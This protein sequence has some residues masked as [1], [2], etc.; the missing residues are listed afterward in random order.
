MGCLPLLFA[1]VLCFS[2]VTAFKAAVY[3]HVQVVDPSNDRN[4]TVEANLRAYANATLNAAKENADII[5][6][7][8][9]G[10]LF[11]FKDREE[12]SKWAENIPDPGVLPCSSNHTTLLANLSC[13][14]L[15]NKI[16]LVANIIDK[17]PCN[18]SD[19][20]CPRDK[21]RF[22]NT[23]V[24]FDRNGTLVSR[25]HK[26]HLF[27]EPLMSPADPPEF[28]VFDTDF[29][30]V[31]MFICFD[32][33]FAESSQLVDKHNVT[34]AIMS[35]WW[36]DGLPGWYSVAVQ[37]AWSLHNRI[38]L[39]AAGIQN[40]E[41]G[42]LGSGIYAGVRGPLNYTYSP[43][44]KS[45]LLFADLAAGTPTEPRYHGDD[46]HPPKRHVNTED[47]SG[48]A[49]QELSAPSGD[50]RVC[51]GDFCCSLSYETSG[52]NDKF[53]LLAKHGLQRL[54]NYMDFG[55]QVCILAVCNSTDHEVC[56]SFPTK[57]STKFSKLQLTGEF[58]T[59]AVF[60]ILASNELAL[61]PKSMWRFE[62]TANNV[63]TLTLDQE[64]GKDEP[65]LQA[66]VYARLYENDR[67]VH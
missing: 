32:V 5:V 59:S 62:S 37:Q 2:A 48:H 34:L 56:K 12:V 16:Y 52:L 29:A 19:H 67:F 4:K 43:D 58:T 41:R 3:E 27:V 45:K 25:Y 55:L 9:D 13:L 28:A 66:M 20:G 64:K 22:F 47:M 21:T 57:S 31:G 60:P 49:S 24:A 8:E 35:S 53:V 14:A 38:P 26:N 42:S 36:F 30:R 54:A 50:S 6:F 10:I 18:E 63:S 65:I 33:F 44:S 15:N 17:K 39:L 40:F 51:H 7:P 1:A 61:T 11:G 23:N 46:V